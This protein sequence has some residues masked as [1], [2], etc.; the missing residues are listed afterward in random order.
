MTSMA[1]ELNDI[2]QSQIRAAT[3]SFSIGAF[4]A[5]AE[6]FCDRKNVP[7]SNDDGVITVVTSQ[8]AMRV[9]SNLNVLPVAYEGLSRD[10][11]CWTHGVALC[12]P[13]LEGIRSC[14]TV[15]TELGP[16]ENAIRDANKNE[17]LFDLGLGTTNIDFCVRTGDA[18]L[19]AELR[20]ACGKSLFDPNMQILDCLIDASPH[21]IVASKLGRIEVYQ[22]LSRHETPRGPHTHL[23]PKLLRA[24]RS[25]DANVPIPKNFLPAFMIYPSS[26]FFD[27]VGERHDY[28]HDNQLAFTFLLE[29]WGP[30]DYLTRKRA[31]S[32]ALL[33]NKALERSLI[34]GSRIERSATRIALRQAAYDPT[35]MHS[36]SLVR[37]LAELNHAGNS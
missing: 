32:R 22:R 29:K 16:D 20:E 8:G 14:R 19:L 37:A 21:R 28:Q 30:Q 2:L 4:G 3:S 26:P 7:I 13:S 31:V 12:V 27:H 36:Q 17:P 5:I 15:I 33:E 35:L 11:K 6:F 10:P 24:K 1:D 34:E 9:S 23:L 25:H 18:T